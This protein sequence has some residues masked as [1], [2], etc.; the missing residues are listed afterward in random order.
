MNTE[1]P[2]DVCQDCSGPNVVWFAPN[3]LWNLVFPRGPDRAPDLILCPTCFIRRAEAKGC[4]KVW[5]VDLS[6]HKK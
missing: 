4:S 6:Q 1:H 5:K 3:D 2:E